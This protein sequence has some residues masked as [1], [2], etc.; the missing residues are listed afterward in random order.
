[1]KESLTHFSKEQI[2]TVGDAAAMAEELVSNSYKMS[3]SQWLWHRYDVKT[4]ADLAPGEIVE[5][6]FAQI[7]RYRGQKSETSLGSSSYDFYKICLMDHTILSA[8]ES[9]R[10]LRL[11]P[12][13]LY[14]LCHELIHIVRFAKFLQSFHASQEEKMAEENRVHQK[15]RE[16]LN[17]VRVPGKEALFAFYKAWEAPMDA[18]I[19]SQ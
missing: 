8:L 16:V 7:V 19:A 9:D 4:L 17:S 2:F 18:A 10:D 15:T 3:A 12:F 13:A 6:P 14:I 1:M 11:F 5:G